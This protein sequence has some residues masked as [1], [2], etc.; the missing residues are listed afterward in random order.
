MTFSQVSFHIIL[1]VKTQMSEVFLKAIHSNQF[2]LRVNQKMSQIKN[3]SY[4]IIT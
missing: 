3:L 4:F 2:S 1:V